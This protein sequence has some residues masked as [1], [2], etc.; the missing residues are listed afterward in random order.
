MPSK[1]IRGANLRAGDELGTG[2]AVHP[3]LEE[4]F[5]DSPIG[6]CLPVYWGTLDVEGRSEKA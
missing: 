4:L 6:L 2:S 1:F 3:S 5:A